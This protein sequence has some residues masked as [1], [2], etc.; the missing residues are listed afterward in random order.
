MSKIPAEKMKV[1]ITQMLANRKERKFP[2]TV[3]LQIGLK[4]YDPNKDKRFAGSVRLPYVPRPRSKVLVIADA[5]QADK[6]KAL[7]IE[8]IDAETLKK[9]ID[10]ADKKGKEIKKWSRK[11]RLL[12]ISESLVRQLPKLGGPFLTRWGKFPTVIQTNDDIKQK[13]EEGLSTVKFQLKKVLCLGV[14]VAN[15]TMNEEQI[16]QNLNMSIN[17][18]ISL[19][20]KGWNNMKTLY[21]RTTM[22]APVK[23]Y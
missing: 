18:L 13:I 19:L 4:D 10:P 14:A 23:L 15:V 22:G 6:C 2:E 1:A 17:Y 5:A 20:K 7:G 8:F 11:Y 3:D 16:R 21:I 9:K 12:F